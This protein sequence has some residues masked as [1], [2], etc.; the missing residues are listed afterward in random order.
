MYKIRNRERKTN[1]KQSLLLTFDGPIVFIINIILE[2]TG[3]SKL[4]SKASVNKAFER[5]GSC[6]WVATQGAGKNQKSGKSGVGCSRSFSTVEIPHI[7]ISTEFG[8]RVGH[9]LPCLSCL[10]ISCT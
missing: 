7:C 9:V 1:K 6:Q 8:F 5:L 2:W 3:I 10:Y 4:A